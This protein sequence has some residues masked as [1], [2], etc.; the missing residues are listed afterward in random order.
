MTTPD[1]FRRL[2]AM[3]A[4]APTNA[5]YTDLA[6]RIDAGGA[7]VSLTATPDL[8][9]VGG[10]VHGAHIFKLLDDAAFFAASSLLTEQFVLT[11][12]FSI[13]LFRPAVSGRLEATGRVTKPGRSVVFAEAVLVR[14]DGKEV[15]RGQGSFAVSRMRLD[16][17]PGYA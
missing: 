17:V 4:S 7:V 14:P 15:A 10:G 5:Q 16:G 12:Q 1:H 2:E 9:H 3:Y 11:A 8:H 6:L 13:Q